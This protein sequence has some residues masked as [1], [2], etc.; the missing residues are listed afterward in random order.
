MTA[1]EYYLVAGATGRQGSKVI[2][3][4]QNE[5]HEIPNKNIFALTRSASGKAA[6]R[7][8][9]AGINVVVGDL[10][11]PEDIFNQ[12]E[13]D[14]LHKT[15]VFLAQAHG[16]TELAEGKAFIDAAVKAGVAH[17]VYSSSDRGGKELSDKDPSNFKVF[18]DKFHIEKHLI[19]ATHNVSTDYTILRP[20]WFADNAEWGFPG[21]LCMAG[22]H[23]QMSGRRLQVMA[24]RDLGRWAA[25]ALVRP[26]HFGLR[27]DAVSVATAEL[28]Y[29]ELN[30]IWTQESGAPV[31]ELSSY[32]ATPI[33]W[34]ASDLSKMFKWFT[35]R[36]FGA[37]LPWLHERLAPTD[38]RS[39]A[40][41]SQIH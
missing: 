19:A 4:L 28:S 15:A 41:A 8:Q 26:D 22:W 25:E 3:A 5:P 1:P 32:L 17:F 2:D 39:L 21:K 23:N 31:P 14:N 33:I 10:S 29:A 16:P 38:I 24:L 6:Q 9:A 34:M 37:D 18:A 12:V 27:N 36:D 40:R 13:H 7:L 30:E 20:T 11:K 35:V